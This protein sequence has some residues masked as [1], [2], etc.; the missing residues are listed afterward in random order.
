MRIRLLRV[1][2]SEGARDFRPVAAEPGV[3]MLDPAGTVAGS[4][5]A[6]L[7]R[8][9][10]EPDWT[11]DSVDF[12]LPGERETTGQRV[13]CRPVTA[14]RLQGELREELDELREQVERAKPRTPT[15]RMLHRHLVE[16]F[17]TLSA[18][19]DRDEV[20]LYLFE[21]KDPES[22]WRLVWCW[23][24]QRS[25][26]EAGAPVIC[27]NSDCSLLF[28]RRK[29]YRAACP[30][31]K[32]HLAG[33]KAPP[34]AWRRY[35]PLA[36]LVLLVAALAYWLLTRNAWGPPPAAGTQ[37]RATPD[38]LVVW[39]G[40]TA[41]FQ[42]VEAVA[43]GR[44][45]RPVAA[46]GLAAPPDQDLVAIEADNLLRGLSAGTTQVVVTA[47]DPEGDHDG[48]TAEATVRVAILD[49]LRVEPARISLRVGET[50]PALVVS[51][52]AEDGTSAEVT[53][54]LES[55]DEAILA[56]DPES[57]GRFVARSLGGTSIRASYGDREVLADVAV[58]GERFVSVETT[59]N[60]RD[61]DFDVTIDVTAAK[62]EGPLEY[63]VYADG[64]T[65]PDNWVAAVEQDEFRQVTLRSPPLEYG[66]PSAT[67]RLI[68]EA[69]DPGGESVDRYPF[70]F[71]L[72]YQLR[73][74]DSL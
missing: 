53:A 64:Q 73:R 70:T 42:R 39:L 45:P 28:V 49:R 63:R 27:R 56:P 26:K 37:L 68:I 50:T 21:Y 40:Q 7:G 1:D 33:K 19:L 20:G 52:E 46:Y 29:G 35:A 69:R 10:A 3:P 74:T 38:P 4:V 44:A 24:Y 36:L 11:D 23:G 48:L 62:S 12:H 25:D 32:P 51:G 2:L 41:G 57:A 66:P 58:T 65:P 59:L 8:F 34:A 55:L 67:Y 31:C 47:F 16:E 14:E 43:E 61:E 71:R 60:E 5:L 9:G 6:W 22:K 30:R 17:R 72:S 13:L 18:L 54:T 15:E